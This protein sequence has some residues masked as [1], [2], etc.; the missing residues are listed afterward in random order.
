MFQELSL[1]VTANPKVLAIDD[2]IDSIRLLSTI[3]SH[4]HC[5]MNLAFDGQDAIPLLQNQNFDLI[6]LDWQMP[7]MG[8]HETLMLLEQIIPLRKKRRP[9]PVLL[10]TS[11]HY[12][13][14][15]L[16][17]LRQ[18]KYVGWID[19]GSSFSAKFRSIGNALALI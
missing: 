7:K 14:L 16:P 5:E 13:Q 9:T 10:Y 1:N 6:I 17:D 4:Y 12:S 8:G 3:L 19:K 11:S 15:T 2:C 18:F